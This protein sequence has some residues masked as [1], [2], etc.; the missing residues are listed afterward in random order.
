MHH[1]DSFGK[2]PFVG[3]EEEAHDMWHDKWVRETSF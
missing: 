2:M 3:G 1:S